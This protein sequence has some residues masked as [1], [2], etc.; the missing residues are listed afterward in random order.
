M[1]DRNSELFA[2]YKK[3]RILLQNCGGCNNPNLR[4]VA[5]HNMRRVA[6]GWPNYYDFQFLRNAAF[7]YN[8]F[9]NFWK[10]IL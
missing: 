7:Y 4:A 5:S 9:C 10:N 6:R 3:V 8:Q 1:L 2:G